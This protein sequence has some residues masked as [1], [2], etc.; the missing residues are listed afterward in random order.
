MEVRP[1][2]FDQLFQLNQ[3]LAPP[4]CETLDEIPLLVL[5]NVLHDPQGVRETIGRAPAS[6]WGYPQGTRNF[7]DYYDCRL[8]YPVFPPLGL[9]ALAQHA[10]KAHYNVSVQPQENGIDINWFMQ[11]HKKPANHACPHQDALVPGKRSFTCLLYLN[12]AEEC[13]GG[14]AF[15]KFRKTQSPVADQRFDNILK[16]DT[17]LQ[18]DA[19]DYWPR[20]PRE[21]WD[22]IGSISM[23]TGRMIIFPAQYFHAAYHPVD[24]FFDFPRLTLVF[25]MVG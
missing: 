15:F 17:R 21:Y 18:Q 2:V 5:D 7:V 16:L 6:A 13:S 14:T 19:L 8:R 9:I 12:S 1:F 25:W 24:S 20:T 4:R 10:I 3:N 22:N 11:I 23:V